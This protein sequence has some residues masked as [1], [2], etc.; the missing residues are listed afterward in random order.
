DFDLVIGE[1][2]VISSNDIITNE[3]SIYFNSDIDY[4]QII[5]DNEDLKDSIME[6]G[7][8]PDGVYSFY[9]RIIFDGNNYEDNFNITV[10]SP[11]ATTLIYPGNSVGGSITSI[12]TSTP[13]FTWSSNQNNF[14]LSIYQFTEDVDDISSL[15]SARPFFQ[16][17]GI[18]SP[19]QYPQMAPSLE[20][21]YVYAWK[22]RTSLDS[23]AGSSYLNSEYFLFNIGSTE[24][25]TD[26]NS[27]LLSTAFDILGLG[28]NQVLQ[29]LINQGYSPSGTFSI[30]GEQHSFDELITIITQLQNEGKSVANITV[31]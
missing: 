21:G 20:P 18:A 8:F 25:M 2:K 10:N 23:P 4:D 17:D 11:G 28:D 30:N 29:N 3:G 26:L 16:I 13:D 24:D 14:A 7:K 15:T 31:E 19:Y 1:Q 27:Q 6:T 5:S 9:F 22:I 12:M